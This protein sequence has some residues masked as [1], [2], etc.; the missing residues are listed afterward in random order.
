MIRIF[1]SL[2]LSSLLSLSFFT[3]T[4]F[5]SDEIQE[6]KSQ[7]KSMEQ[8]IQSLKSRVEELESKQAIQSQEVAKIPEI[9]SSVE[10]LKDS[11]VSGNWFDNAR[12]GGHF[13]MYLFDKAD[14]KRNDSRQGTN[15]S[16]G[17]SHVYFF[18]DKDISDNTSISIQ[19][20]ITVTAG[21]TPSLGSNITRSSSASVT[22]SLFQAFIKTTMPGGLEIKAGQ[23]TPLFAEEYGAQIWW[24]EQYHQNK[25]LVNLEAWHDMGIELYKSLEFKHFSM[26]TYFY[27]LNGEG[28]FVDNN[29]GKSIMLHVSPQVSNF[30]LLGSLTYGKWDDGDT[31]NTY[32]YVSGFE[33][34]YKKLT[35][36][37]EY[38]FKKYF[39]KPLVDKSLVDT[40]SFGYY[41]KAL[42][43][44]NPKW[45]AM[46]NYSDVQLPYLGERVIRHDDYE[47]V[48]LGL[49][50]YFTE[51]SIIMADISLVD[52]DR[53]ND[54]ESLNYYRTTLGWR[55][56]F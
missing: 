40:E 51:S 32:G 38:M 22:T 46:V 6:L 45:G 14:G 44:F 43:R 42:Y 39:N 10:Q 37:S 11:P 17:I 20:D 12:L 23:F 3:K 30:R 24:D 35:L 1:I 31:Y 48:T 33:Y 16:A 26:P 34:K 55:T 27:L 8:V 54:S 52:A 21:A 19:P 49:N 50:Y 18:I 56:T 4:L 13:K 47:A 41:L 2:L 53:S 15:I 36:R 28:Q 5:A 29:D 7:I 25:G 9:K